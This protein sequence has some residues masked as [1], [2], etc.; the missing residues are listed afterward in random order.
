MFVLIMSTSCKYFY[1]FYFWNSSS[2][3]K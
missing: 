2:C 1:L 3:Y